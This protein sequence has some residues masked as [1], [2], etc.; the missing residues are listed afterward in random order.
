VDPV[1][2][3]LM[4]REKS[5]NA[6]NRTRDNMKDTQILLKLTLI[7]VLLD[8]GTNFPA[9]NLNSLLAMAII[10]RRQR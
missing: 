9:V 8:T 7:R 2:D 10:K 6:G 4:L 5:G 1:P 3:P